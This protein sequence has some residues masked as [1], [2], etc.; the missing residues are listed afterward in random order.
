MLLFGFSLL[1]AGV[2]F[3]LNEYRISRNSQPVTA[4]VTAVL[5]SK[6]TDGS[7][8]YR[9]EISY[10]YAGLEQRYLPDF[11]SLQRRYEI[12]DAVELSV[13]PEGARIPSAY[14]YTIAIG[15]AIISGVLFFVLGLRWFLSSYRHYNDTARLKRIGV[16]TQATFLQQQETRTMVDGHPGV[17]LVLQDTSSSKTFKTKPIHSEFSIK[18]LEEHSFDVYVDPV[19]TNKYF[20]DLEKHFGHPVGQ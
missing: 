12:G 13:S 4:E 16:R 8:S 3:A 18:W 7:I 20:I 11:G 19:D 17:I 14:S 1:L 6:N 15:I 9:P 5:Q 2:F 10:Q